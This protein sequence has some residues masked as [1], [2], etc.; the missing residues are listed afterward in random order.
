MY[1][2]LHMFSGLGL[3]PDSYFWQGAEAALFISYMTEKQ[4]TK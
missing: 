1:P 2:I 3:L 4:A